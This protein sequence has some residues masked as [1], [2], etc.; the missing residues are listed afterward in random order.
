MQRLL[1]GC[2]FV[3]TIMFTFDM[4]QNST[5]RLMGLIDRIMQTNSLLKAII[6]CESAMLAMATIYINTN[7]TWGLF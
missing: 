7:N 4:Q 1:L 3:S 6:C 5:V 2:N